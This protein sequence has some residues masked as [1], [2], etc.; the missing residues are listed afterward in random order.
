MVWFRENWYEEVLRQ[1]KQGLAKCYS[2]AFE[3]RGAG[4]HISCIFLSPLHCRLQIVSP[5]HCRLVKRWKFNKGCLLVATSAHFDY[6]FLYTGILQINKVLFILTL[7]P[8]SYYHSSFICA[9][10]RPVTCII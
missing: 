2:I 7:A 1:L 10:C 4:K 6:T 8:F 9:K 5:L 3:N